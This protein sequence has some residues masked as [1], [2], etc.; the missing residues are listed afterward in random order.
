MV[1]LN[2]YLKYISWTQ[3]LLGISA[4]QPAIDVNLKDLVK[5]EKADKSKGDEWLFFVIKIISFTAY[6]IFYTPLAMIFFIYYNFLLTQIKLKKYWYI[7]S[8]LYD[9]NLSTLTTYINNYCIAFLTNEEKNQRVEY[10][11]VLGRTRSCKKS[12]LEKLQKIDEKL[13]PNQVIIVLSK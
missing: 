9:V 3:S 5:S 1:F 13:K 2:T 12:E 7:V 11:D 8:K 4:S 6:T 10:V